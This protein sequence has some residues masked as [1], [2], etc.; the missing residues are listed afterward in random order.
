[1]EG[2]VV[3]G[4]R[5]EKRDREEGVGGNERKNGGRE[6]EEIFLR[7]APRREQ[8]DKGPGGGR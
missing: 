1:M 6:K 2:K 5:K 7:A 4:G 8:G 3:R